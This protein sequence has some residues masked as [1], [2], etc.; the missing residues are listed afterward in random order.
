[1]LKMN[2]SLLLKV[3][4]LSAHDAELVGEVVRY[5]PDM[6][7]LGRYHRYLVDNQDCLDSVFG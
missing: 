3:A 6:V 1:M 5:D 4:R 7:E 2:R